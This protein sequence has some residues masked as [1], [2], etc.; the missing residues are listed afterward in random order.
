MRLNLRQNAI[1]LLYRI[2]DHNLNVRVKFFLKM[3][4]LLDRNFR[5]RRINLMAITVDNRK[6]VIFSIKKVSPSLAMEKKKFAF[7]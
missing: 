5:K 3:T 7:Q 1:H 6:L 2:L 4:S